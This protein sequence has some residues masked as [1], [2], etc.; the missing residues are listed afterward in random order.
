MTSTSVLTAAPYVVCRRRHLVSSSPVAA[1]ALLLTD[2]RTIEVVDYDPTW[3]VLFVQL[4][5][6]VWRPVG[7]I[8]LAVEH[9]LPSPLFNVI[10]R[11]PTIGF[12]IADRLCT[13]PRYRVVRLQRA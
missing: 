10:V 11:Q 13:S 9:A 4:R 6:Y 7:D 3:P 5:P 12:P 2:M 1:E 8:A